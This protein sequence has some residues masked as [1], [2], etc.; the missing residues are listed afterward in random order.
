MRI[1]RVETKQGDGPYRGPLSDT[2]ACDV[3]VPCADGLH[4]TPRDEMEF[5]PPYPGLVHKWSARNIQY[6][7]AFNDQLNRWF[8]GE[9]FKHLA[10]H[11]FGVAEYDID[12]RA[13]YV[14]PTQCI[15]NRGA[16]SCKRTSWTPLSKLV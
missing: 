16:P 15:F 5:F 8:S 2:F 9:W 6:G 11:G 12:A 3:D 14:T 13:V 1:Y 10:P 4:P 7:F